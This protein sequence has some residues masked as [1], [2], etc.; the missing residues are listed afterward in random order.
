MNTKFSVALLL[1]GMVISSAVLADKDMAKGG[2]AFGA[3]TDQNYIKECGSCHMPFPP[4]ALP[5]RSWEKLMGKLNDHF[6]E[7]AELADAD[8]KSLTNY[9]T[10][11]AA[12]HS[13]GGYAQKF[14]KSLKADETPLRISE[15]PKFV[16]EHREV[17]KRVFTAHPELKNLS[18][19]EGCHTRADKDSFRESEI[20]IPG[21]GRGGD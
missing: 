9:L 8:R 21:V 15:I 12:E 6:G 11:N 20:N 14:L 5:A 3:V 1:G 18:K 2:A 7:N 19:C 17:P 16:K 10:A 13:N 4:G